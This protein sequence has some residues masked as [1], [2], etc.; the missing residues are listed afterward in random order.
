MVLAL[1]LLLVLISVAF[2]TLMERKVLGYIILRVGPNK[3]CLSGLLV[4]FADA[5]K[6]L[7]KIAI[8]PTKSSSPAIYSSC[9]ILF[10]IPALL[11]SVLPFPST[12]ISWQLRML[13]VL[14]L[15]SF[16]IFGLLSGGWGS[17]RKYAILGATRCVAQS[18]SYEVCLS[19]IFLI[20]GLFLTL[21]FLA[22]SP[23]FMLLVTTHCC[24][25][26]FLVFLAESNRSPFDLAEGESEL[27][28]G[29]N[30]EYSGSLF[31]LLFLSEY[32]GILF[33]C[34]LCA[35]LCTGSF[36]LLTI[37]FCLFL[38]F[39]FIWCRASL[40]RLRYDSLIVLCWQSLLPVLLCRL[41][42][43]L[44]F[45]YYSFALKAIHISVMH[46]Q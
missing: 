41:T 36:Y 8:L 17:N 1:S 37:F 16:S 4:P 7:T 21:D 45:Y 35:C 40:P 30:V 6:L 38:A 26:L 31:V 18:I 10:L 42:A 2:F 14:V 43:Y 19:L 15:F 12:P 29:Y 22:P 13:F 46:F 25:L 5:L 24:F 27:V 39:S 20:F 28:S 11:W 32:L 33:L 23:V 3:P 34:Y 9:L 44:L